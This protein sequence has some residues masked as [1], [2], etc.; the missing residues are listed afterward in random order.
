MLCRFH[1]PVDSR[2]AIRSQSETRKSN[3]RKFQI[4]RQ[5]QNFSTPP[6]VFHWNHQ[7]MFWGQTQIPSAIPSARG[8]LPQKTVQCGIGLGRGKKVALV[9][10]RSSCIFTRV[11]CARQPRNKMAAG[12][13][14]TKR[15]KDLQRRE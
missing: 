9:S 2:L 14:A 3:N 4:N 13:E 5:C 8:R 6:D 15:G 7:A 11:H 1:R 10:A 12:I